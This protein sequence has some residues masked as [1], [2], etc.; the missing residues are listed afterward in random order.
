MS[1]VVNSTLPQLVLQVNVLQ[2]QVFYRGM[3]KGVP[4]EYWKNTVIPALYPLWDTEK[5]RLVVFTYYNNNTYHAQ[6][7]KFIK[8]FKTNE[9]EW[10]DY[11]MEQMDNDE[12]EK[13]Y[14]L[15]RQSFYLVDSLENEEFQNE[16]AS[17]YAEVASVTWLTIRLARNFLLSETDWIFNEDSEVSEEDKILWKKYRKALRDLPSNIT[18]YTP[19]NVKFPINPK[20]Y[21]Q[22][23]AEA[24]P[25]IEY[26]DRGDQ[27][28][29]LGQ[30]Y[31]TTFKEKMVRYLVVCETTEQ[32][33]FDSFMN[34]LKE[35]PD[36]GQFPKPPAFTQESDYSAQLD[37]LLEFVKS[38][39]TEWKDNFRQIKE[40]TQEALEEAK[41]LKESN[42]GDENA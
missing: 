17:V 16:L 12:A 28:I 4:E 30:H 21:K 14:E 23:Y 29:A 10:V 19:T 33:Y 8:N 2:K 40:L 25:G 3:T 13:I 42:V 37:H 26:L 35:Q 36:R 41:S 34:K 6:R 18:D 5:D 1:I 11:E 39:E 20:M 32:V 31:L 27:F 7:R 15:F 38:E 22:L 9:F 24:N